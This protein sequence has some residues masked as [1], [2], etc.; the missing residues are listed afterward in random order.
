[1]ILLILSFY[2]QVSILSFNVYVVSFQLCVIWGCGEYSIYAFM[3]N[4]G[5]KQSLECILLANF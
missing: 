4:H 2:F 5:L 1:M 3:W